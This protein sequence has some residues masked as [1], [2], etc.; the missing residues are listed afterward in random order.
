MTDESS[1]ADAF[2]GT[3][4]DARDG[5]ATATRRTALKTIGAA[6]AGG[7]LLSG[8]ASAGVPTPRLHTDGKWIRDPQ[9][10]AVQLRGMATADPAF[11]R[12]THP[13]SFEE[14]L[15]WATDTERG[16]H[17]N[18]VRLPFTQD[19]VAHYGI[20]TLISEFIRPAVDILAS[21]DVYALVDFHLIRPYTQ[22]ATET[23]N[24]ENEDT[25]DPIDDVMRNF[26]NAVAPEF[27]DD[28]HV[29]YELFNEPTQPTMYGDDEGAWQTWRDAAQPWVDLVRGHA[30]ETPI[31][32]GSPRWTSVTHMAPEYPFE[33]ENLIYAAHIYPDNGAPSEFDQYYGEPANDVPV[34]V[35]EFG[36][37]PDGGSVDQ[38]TTSGWGEPF[39]QWAEGY[40]N[41]GWIS[42][43][44]DD[45]WAP[46]FFDS[47]G[48]GAAEPWTLKTGADQMG[49]YIKTWL[50]ETQSDSVP[51]SP[52]DDSIAPPAP[53]NPTVSNATEI[54][55]DLSWDAVTDEGEAGLSH[56]TVYLDGERVQEALPGATTT[57]VAG[58]SPG[59][60]YEFAVTAE[61]D[62]G[63]E[64]DP[65]TVVAETIARDAGQS[66]YNG[67]HTLP[68][69]VQA[70][71]F[72]EGGQ[73][74]SY[75]DTTAANQG[76][77]SYRDTA[78]DIGTSANTGYN[79]G[80]ISTGEWLEYTVQVESAGSR[81]TRVNVSAGSGGGGALRISVDGETLATQ[82]VWQTGGWSN[83]QTIRV[84]DLDL[85]EGEH[86]VRVTA[87]S[88]AW[89]FDWIEF[90]E[91]EGSADT[92]A[93]PAPTNLSVTGTTS[94]S[95]SVDWDAV[96]D[97]GGS[98]L[99][100]YA[101]HVDGSE[102]QTV[103]AGT[104]SA[105]VDGLSAE[106]SYTVAVSA[107][108][109]AGNESAMT[110]AS[111]TTDAAGDSTAPS[112][113][114]NLS[115]T[116]T[117]SSSVSVGWDAVTDSG[118]SG[119]DHYVVSLDGSEDRT[120]AAGTTA[121]T[122]DGLSADSSYEVGVAAVDGAGNASAVA[123]VTATT[124]ASDD[125]GGSDGETPADAMVVDDYDG[126]P[127]W[128]SHRNDLGQWCG[129]GS[130][131]N[132]GGEVEDGAL[133]LE[134]DNGGWFQ[135]QIN[136]DVSGYS[137]L[138]FEISGASGGEESEVLFDMGGVRTMLANV[139]DDSIG[140]STSDVRVDMESAGVDR[141]SPS[142]RLNFWQGGASTLTIEE[143]RLE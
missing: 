142:V 63:N 76:G 2:D 39:R 120:V 32:I 136:E 114:A 34:V 119:L 8:R 90:G 12:R 24:S 10:N 140:T 4:E 48:E 46:T 94:T 93:P 141:S 25:L 126:D 99:E 57:T 52:I 20:D 26:W 89:N 85:P 115:V 137:T 28:E 31:V 61:D 55:V 113:P 79:V 103:A 7:T 67:P 95:I 69:R 125:G 87:E 13:K 91:S 58:L 38:G 105:T 5:T 138:V 108:D 42:W 78:V 74:V 62:A 123:T 75:Y 100:S 134:Y 112:A 132:G 3:S 9:G 96:T 133:V 124:D 82:D 107:V 51:A 18:V 1:P 22:E 84:G 54:S 98:G 36:W 83:W 101:V 77:A 11:Y 129:A 81:T 109:G 49:G 56:Y 135:E 117:S 43:C 27:A 139:T 128:S 97:T 68:G 70:E 131:A 122:V 143:I 15:R 29:V 17:P 72:D 47:P 6:A 35:T 80:Y 30:P 14:V 102:V 110:S 50:D 106:T 88:G 64:S 121:V 127:G 104:T 16:W 40:A 118:G 23:Y 60:T 21:R 71:D 92:T 41:M 130:F 116:G 59:T 37:D 73:G 66:P 86:V 19:N 45:S 65:A 44:F 53:A 111:A 33:G